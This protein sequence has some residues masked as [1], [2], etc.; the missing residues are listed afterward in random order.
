M[1]RYFGE[2][3]IELLAPVG[4]FND[5]QEI[6]KSSADAVYFGGKK[7]NMRMHRSNYNL[8]Y[9][10]IESAVSTAHSLG[11]K[12]YITFNNMM[13]DEEIEEAEDYLLF[14]D[15]VKPDALIVQDFGALKRIRE[16]GLNLPLHLSVMAN[17]HNRQMIDKALELGVTRVVVSREMPLETIRQL[18]RETAMEF[19]YFIH[20]DM[21]VTHGAQCLYS[22]ILF[23]KSSNRGLCMKPCRWPF[24]YDNEQEEFLYPLAVKDISLYRHLPELIQSGVC[25][26][27]IEGRIRDSSYLVGLINLYGQAI[28]RYISDPTGYYIDDEQSSTLYENRV[29]NLSTAYAFKKPGSINIDIEGKREPKV[30]SRAVEEFEINKERVE[31]IK[32]RVLPEDK[33]DQKTQLAVK[34]NSLDALKKAVDN[35]ADILYLAGEVFKKDRPFTKKDIR[36]AVA[37]SGDR[38]VYYVLPRMMYPRQFEEF[39]FLVKDLKALGI[40]GLLISN[41]G[42][43]KEYENSGLELIGDFGLNCYNSTSA[44]FYSEQGLSRITASIE[45][46]FKV[47]K[48]LLKNSP[49]DIEVIVQGAPTVMYM[50]HCIAASK[51]GVTSHDWC[52]DY[53][54]KRDM[55]LIDEIGSSHPIY[56]DQ[57]CKNHLLP[58][59][60]LCCLPVYNVLSS[61]GVK[62]ARIEGQHYSPEVLGKVVSLYRNLC[63]LS[64]TEKA[65]KLVSKLK[66]ITGRGQS[67]HALN[68]D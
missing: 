50:E 25:S 29:R 15:R 23:G 68:Y 16:L 52:E 19:E 43:I 49:V 54:I 58:V 67:L 53:C 32:S 9:E 21:C 22:G 28:D 3:E 38:K 40:S 37:Y 46:P 55:H 18:S 36:E 59:K 30:F 39:D 64:G 14:L 62:V 26:F 65:F 6:I 66:N 11:K 13:S 57:Y 31:K 5:F 1:S 2:R 51:H 41:L 44:E 34:V 10:E 7:F 8:T 35:G 27:K 20:G 24:K 42:Q 45:A 48:S 63:D 61:L 33:K 47:L 56:A 12:V 60:D 4:T 17:V